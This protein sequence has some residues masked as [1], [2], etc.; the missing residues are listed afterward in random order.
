MTE[1]PDLTLYRLIHRGMRADTARLAA[2]VAGLTEAERHRRMPALTRWY[3]GFLQEFELHHSAEDDIFF[4]A[5]A[6]RLPVFA[7]QLARLDA[8]HHSLEAA[9]LAVRDALGQLAD[10][11]VAWRS[12]R[13]D[14]VD[15]LR[16]ADSELTLHL[17]NE[18]ADVLP[19]F[20]SHMSKLEYDEI[21]ERALKRATPKHLLFALPLGDAAGH[22]RG[23]REDPGRG[24]PSPQGHVVR[25]PRPARPAHQ[26]GPGRDGRPRDAGAGRIGRPEGSHRY[27]LRIWRPM[28][29][30]HSGLI[31]QPQGR[32][33]QYG[34]VGDEE[35][36]PRLH[37]ECVAP[38]AIHAGSGFCRTTGVPEA[39]VLGAP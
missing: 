9:L 10:L 36:L 26:P 27:V 37:A 16:A 38:G 35:A 28:A 8:E 33:D 1:H 29:A 15:A 4:P 30:E 32:L 5:L 2:V 34:V 24:P 23:E 17:D 3:A 7:D 6:E 25:Q 39:P 19:L 12:V 18:D 13:E 22:R 21:G 20:V 14:A 31:S 11:N